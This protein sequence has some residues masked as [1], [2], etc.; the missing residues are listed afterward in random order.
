MCGH[1]QAY[2]CRTDSIILRNMLYK[3]F[4]IFYPFMIPPKKP[5]TSHFWEY[6]TLEWCK[7]DPQPRE[8]YQNLWKQNLGREVFE[9][10]KL[11]WKRKLV[12]ISRHFTINAH[13][14][15]LLPK[16]DMF[17]VLIFWM[18]ISL[19]FSLVNYMAWAISLYYEKGPELR[20]NLFACV[21]VN[22]LGKQ[23]TRNRRGH[24]KY[25]HLSICH[26]REQHRT[27]RENT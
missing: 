19:Y 23:S 5:K 1:I 4:G 20:P 26:S 15:Q 10:L 25:D 3:I 12:R 21:S 22:F 18:L 27:W 8:I 24:W 2:V 13:L 17:Y 9:T 14:I 11:N 6:S 7:D 16:Q